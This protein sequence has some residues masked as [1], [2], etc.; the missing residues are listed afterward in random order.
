MSVCYTHTYQSTWLSEFQGLCQHTGSGSKLRCDSTSA[1]LTQQHCKG[2]NNAD[3]VCLCSTALYQ[4]T[5]IR[6]YA[7]AHAHTHAHNRLTAIAGTRKTLTHSH[8]CW[9]S[10]ILYQLPPFTTTVSMQPSGVHLS[11]C[12]YHLAA[13]AA[14]LLLWAQQATDND[15]S[16]NIQQSAAAQ[17]RRDA[18][19]ATLSASVAPE[20]RLV[21]YCYNLA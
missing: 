8:P 17:W 2:V 14:G 18:S 21:L 11:A 15:R 19:S 6:Q 3:T 13:A 5:T 20:H 9:S 16:P 4:L 12:L 10:D 7:H 1:M